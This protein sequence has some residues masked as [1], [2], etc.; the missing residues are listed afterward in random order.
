M[1][2][3]SS[4]KTL[5]VGTNQK[6]IL[7]VNIEMFLDPL[8]RMVDFANRKGLPQ[9]GFEDSPGNDGA[10]YTEEDELNIQEELERMGYQPGF[11]IQD[12][13]SNGGEASN[14]DDMQK[15]EK[16]LQE[17]KTRDDKE[18]RR[19]EE[20]GNDGNRTEFLEE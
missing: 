20:E 10:G 6:S 4:T 13:L 2:Y 16:L 5:F 3:L 9:Y 7:T 8:I 19:G 1:D 18:R 17:L 15:I 12:L 11:S 14:I